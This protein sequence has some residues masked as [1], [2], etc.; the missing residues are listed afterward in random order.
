MSKVIGLKGI[1]EF[2]EK[3]NET[4]DDHFVVF[5]AEHEQI[6]E[7]IKLLFNEPELDSQADDMIQKLEGVRF[8]AFEIVSN[9]IENETVVPV[10]AFLE[11]IGMGFDLIWDFDEDLFEPGEDLCFLDMVWDLFVEVKE[12]DLVE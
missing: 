8:I 1:D 9:L 10:V 7:I 6:K 12:L 4:G 2:D 5:D 11:V 3:V